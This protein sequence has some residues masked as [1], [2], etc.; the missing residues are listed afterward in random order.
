M[1]RHK[2]TQLVWNMSC[3]KQAAH[4]QLD[5][6]VTIPFPRFIVSMR[7]KIKIL[8]TRSFWIWQH[9]IQHLVCQLTVVSEMW[10]LLY[11]PLLLLH[12][13]CVNKQIDYYGKPSMFFLEAL[14]RGQFCQYLHLYATAR[15]SAGKQ[16]CNW[17]DVLCEMLY[18]LHQ[19]T[20]LKPRS[21]WTF[22]Y[23]YISIQLQ[24]ILILFPYLTGKSLYSCIRS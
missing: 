24:R 16:E 9:I 5:S 4:F 19:I 17:K 23:V 10:L 11:L 15:T 7:F 1:S 6:E 8:L 14:C 2:P 22:K 12:V 18:Q 21:S 13:A 3:K 20:I